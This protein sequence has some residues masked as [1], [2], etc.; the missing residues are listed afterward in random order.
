[1]P[2]E[3][4]V[5][6]RPLRGFRSKTVVYMPCD[7]PSGLIS[8]ELKKQRRTGKHI[9]LC[10][11]HVVNN[12]TVVLGALGAP[13]AALVLEMLIESGAKDII[14]LGFCGSLSNRF[15]IGDTVS[16]TGAHADEGTSRHYRPRRAFF[17]PSASLKEGLE[18]ALRAR[19]LGFKTGEVVS[20]DAPYRETRSWL[21]KSRRRGA[22]V[23]DMETSA[24]FA[25]AESRGVRAASLQ[26]V[27]DELGSG[28]WRN[29]FSSALLAEA[30]KSAFVPFL[31]DRERS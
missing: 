21:E 6:P 16:I 3:S 29:G 9:G 24:V 1:M 23:V 18:R 8:R 26:I 15:Q 5:K 31:F 19:G 11:L 4:I 20:T 27:G 17:L 12:L 28:K 22:E 7:L 2:S 14:L 10:D 30:A 13:A 25:L